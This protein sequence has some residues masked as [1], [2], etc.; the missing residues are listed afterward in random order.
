M[1]SPFVCT[2]FSMLSYYTTS[3]VVIC[4]LFTYIMYIIL[5][6]SQKRSALILYF[7]WLLYRFFF[8]A[9]H[10][11]MLASITYSVASVHVQKIQ[12]V[13]LYQLNWQ[14]AL[15][16]IVHSHALTDICTHRICVFIWLLSKFEA[17]CPACH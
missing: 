12:M 6:S 1:T 10:S 2:F 14:R 11:F 9:S 15:Q 7:S 8:F 13:I 3:I 16:I 17:Y 5:S 4:F